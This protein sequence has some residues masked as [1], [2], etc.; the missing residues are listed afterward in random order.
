[1]LPQ[2]RHFTVHNPETR[3]ARLLD[4]PSRTIGEGASKT[5]GQ[6]PG[7][8]AGFAGVGSRSLESEGNPIEV[9]M[10]RRPA[11]ADFDREWA[12]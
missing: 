5:R 12:V 1:M 11:A 8:D 2:A 10:L 6:V 3:R 9:V 4:T 7:A